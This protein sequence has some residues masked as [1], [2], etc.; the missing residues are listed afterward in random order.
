MSTKKQ[1][2]EAGERQAAIDAEEIRISGL[3]AQQRDRDHR[4]W[5]HEREVDAEVKRLNQRPKRNKDD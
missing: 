4:A 5:Q 3:R 2:R 1:R